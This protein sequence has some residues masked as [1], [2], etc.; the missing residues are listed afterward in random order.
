[1]FISPGPWEDQD[2]SSLKAWQNGR[3]FDNQGPRGAND[4]F[5][6]R[7]V[8]PDA[9]LQDLAVA[10][11]P[12]ATELEGLSRKWLRDVVA[13]EPVGGVSDEDL[14][15]ACPD[16]DAPYE[17][18]STEI[19]ARDSLWITSTP[20]ADD[21]PATTT[22]GS[23]SSSKKNS[24]PN[25]ASGGIIAVAVLAS[26]LVLLVVGGLSYYA[27][28]RLPP[29]AAAPPAN[30]PRVC[31][32][33]PVTKAAE[34]ARATPSGGGTRPRAPGTRARAQTSCTLPAGCLALE[35][36]VVA[37]DGR[38]GEDRVDVGAARGDR[39]RPRRPRRRRP[40]GAPD[41]VR[42]ERIDWI[43]RVKRPRPRR[44]RT[45]A[46]RRRRRRS[47]RRRRDRVA[48]QRGGG[49]VDRR[50][51]RLRRGRPREPFQQV[52]AVAGGP[53]D[54]LGPG[55]PR[56]AVLATAQRRRW[57]PVVPSSE[58]HVRRVWRPRRPPR[59]RREAA[60]RAEGRR[61]AAGLAAAAVVHRAQVR[62]AR[63]GDVGADPPQRRGEVGEARRRGARRGWLLAG[64]S[65]RRDARGPR[66]RRRGG[67]RGDE[68][69]VPRALPRRGLRLLRDALRPLP[70]LG[71]LLC[72]VAPELRSASGCP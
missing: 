60:R 1:M 47:P 10:F 39:R 36:V 19:C 42:N 71:A 45:R 8:E 66:P 26:A 63:V 69:A 29:P 62:V 7:V 27:N 2:V 30:I 44:P 20:R 41:F 55:P 58:R 59:P 6:R 24:S 70:V 56:G 53:R 46:T 28:R 72:T 54:A 43:L 18:S 13:E 49:A 50:G 3:V 31:N 14:D 64:R 68:G 67:A 61:R 25:A 32:Q 22:E 57:W 23:S 38:P 5:E 35:E 11:Y 48:A 33:Q 15:T 37:L 21:G 16:I 65:P 4:W 9:V 40:R 52:D 17:F 12:D 34:T 51:R